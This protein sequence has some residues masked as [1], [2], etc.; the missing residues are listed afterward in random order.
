LASVSI[1]N[2][3]CLVKFTKNGKEAPLDFSLLESALPGSYTVPG[4][5][6]YRHER[7]SVSFMFRG[8]GSARAAIALGAKSLRAASEASKK[9]LE[10]LRRAGADVDGVSVYVHNIVA[11]AKLERVNLDLAIDALASK[12][13]LK[14]LYE[15][16]VFP[17]LI[18][19]ATWYAA[20]VFSTGK[21]VILGVKR[22]ED[23]AMAA[24]EL[25]E[26]LKSA[27]AAGR[28]KSS[29]PSLW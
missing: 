28:I 3:V 11:A 27:G 18:V 2:V 26:H 20:L 1:V 15:P 16:E 9:V 10:L 25:E 7:P 22:E 14:V 17:G 13:G 24:R 6:V 29:A 8:R 4:G 21:A 5:L 12:P 23:A 19:K